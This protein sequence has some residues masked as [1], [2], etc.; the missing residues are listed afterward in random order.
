M[1]AAYRA[2]AVLGRA[3]N[4]D[5]QKGSEMRSIVLLGLISL[6]M[7]GSVQAERK[8]RGENLLVGLPSGYEVAH[9]QKT[10]AGEISEFVP[11]GETVENWS[12]MLTIQLLPPGNEVEGF[13]ERFDSMVKQVCGGSTRVVA[14]EEENGYTVKF[15]HM[16]CPSNPQTDTGETTF[17][18][19][20]EGKDKFYA[21]QKAWRTEEYGPGEVPLTEEDIIN[22]TLFMKSVTV[23]D[24]R[25]KGKKCP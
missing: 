2:R 6:F 16:Y 20:I 22:W 13:Y 23:C 18:K 25:I 3:S 8:L 4:D 12:E 11:E 5:P 17:I 21:V 9:H 1:M 10:A 14:T 19:A 7:T 24:T 15:F